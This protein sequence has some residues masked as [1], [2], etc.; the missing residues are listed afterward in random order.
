[1]LQRIDEGGAYANLVLSGALDRSGL[2]AADRRFVTDLVYGT[3]R[4]RR[5]CDH[6]VD[7]F[8]ARPVDGRVRNALRLGAYQLAFA[9]VPAH[10]AVGETVEVTPRPARGLVNAVLRRVAGAPVAWPD[11]ATRLSVPDWVL[12]ELTGALGPERARDALAA[13]N[14]PARVSEREDGYVQDPASQQVAA[15]V[16]ARAGERVLDVCAAPG[17][18]A[19]A[20]AGAGAWVAA[21]DVR[22][23]RVELVRDNARLVGGPGA[24]A[25]VTADGTAPPW[26]PA[27][28]D[29]VLVDAPCT[30]LG[31]L[32]RRPDLRW[33]VEESAIERL[34]A[35]Q[36]RLVGAAADLVRPGGT[37][38]YSVCTLTVA[39]TLGVDEWLA[40]GRPDLRPLAPPGEPWEP[41]GRGAILLPQT[42]GTDGMCLFRYTRPAAGTGGDETD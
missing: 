4:M 37:L 33:R 27:R 2:R 15:A 24:I 17:G 25:A 35:L 12:D 10:A 7:R 9:G 31:T 26:R 30:G 8:L 42:A 5:A 23:G 13:M 21:A 39:E 29:R 36:R 16:G 34:A 1:M 38:V 11:D 41:W 32:R 40:A 3:T 20:M 18:K 28:F 22:P 19:T 6:L 14:E